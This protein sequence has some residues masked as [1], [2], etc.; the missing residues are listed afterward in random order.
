M[1]ITLEK[2]KNLL[3]EKYKN[4]VHHDG[5]LIFERIIPIFIPRH[6]G[7]VMECFQLYTEG[8]SLLNTKAYMPTCTY[9]YVCLRCGFYFDRFEF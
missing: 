2:A 7:K 4:P 1:K 3:E 8:K 6:C 5:P 9:I